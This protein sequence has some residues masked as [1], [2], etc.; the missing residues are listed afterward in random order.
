M[1]GIRHASDVVY[2]FNHLPKSVQ[3][4]LLRQFSQLFWPAIQTAQNFYDVVKNLNTTSKTVL[5]HCV[6]EYVFDAIHTVEDFVLIVMYLRS[7][8]V[9]QVWEQCG[10]LTPKTPRE[11]GQLM[12]V[13]P[14]TCHEALLASYHP[15]LLNGLDLALMLRML[16][17]PQMESISFWLEQ[18]VPL[19]QIK[20][21]DDFDAIMPFLNKTQRKRI[22]EKIWLTLPEMIQDSKD[23]NKIFKYLD[24]SQIHLLFYSVDLKCI[25]HTAEDIKLIL[26]SLPVAHVKRFYLNFPQTAEC[27]GLILG[28]LPM[29]KAELLMFYFPRGLSNGESFANM[30]M[31]LDKPHQQQLFELFFHKFVTIIKTEEDLKQC[32]RYLDTKQKQLILMKCAYHIYQWTYARQLLQTVHPELHALIERFPEYHSLAIA[33]LSHQPDKIEQ[34]FRQF[35]GNMGEGEQHEKKYL[36][37]SEQ[38]ATLYPNWTHVFN[39]SLHLSLSTGEEHTQDVFR[40]VIHQKIQE[41]VQKPHTPRL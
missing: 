29:E 10:S 33:L 37:I 23:F 15:T 38:L 26:A 3:H 4:Q 5:F 32:C 34:E 14:S 8:Q 13:L 19:I 16:S 6:K 35:L 2:F 27:W 21:S 31:F 40:I 9:L 12:K 28:T 24:Y 17:K 30:Q 22:F 20:H 36:L 39:Q 7:E 25:C 41:M 1:D 18:F 11:L